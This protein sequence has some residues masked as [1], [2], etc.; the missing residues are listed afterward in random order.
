[1][2][3]HTRIVPCEHLVERP[4]TLSCNVH[5][6]HLQNVVHLSQALCCLRR[7]AR[8]SPHSGHP[9]TTKTS[10]SLNV[11]I[12]LA[13]H[14]TTHCIP[15]QICHPPHRHLVHYPPPR[16]AVAV[17]LRWRRGHLCCRRAPAEQPA[18]AMGR[19]GNQKRV[20]TEEQRSTAWTRET[21]QRWDDARR[22]AGGPLLPDG[23]GFPAAAQWHVQGHRAE[24]RARSSADAPLAVETPAPGAK[25]GASHR[26]HAEAQDLAEAGRMWTEVTNSCF[27]VP[28]SFEPQQYLGM[29]CGR[30]V[31]VTLG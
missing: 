21:F 8:R 11:P 1:M 7:C 14:P 6:T 27:S 29:V 10:T 12:R 4:Q 15:L 30:P 18:P 28:G 19:R 9:R 13:P 31:M 24:S 3:Y 17:Q 22:G 26:P 2:L 25:A 23:V 20:T 5:V 16:A